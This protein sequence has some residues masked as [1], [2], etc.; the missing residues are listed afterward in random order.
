MLLES[1]CLLVSCVS[2]GILLLKQEDAAQK[3]IMVDACAGAVSQAEEDADCWMPQAPQLGITG[4]SGR[5]G[6]HLDM[7]SCQQEASMNMFGGVSALSIGLL[8]PDA[9]SRICD[10]G[11]ALRW[12]YIDMCYEV[13]FI[14]P[15]SAPVSHCSFGSKQQVM[16]V[17]CSRLD[18]IVPCTSAQQPH[19]FHATAAP[20]QFLVAPCTEQLRLQSSAEP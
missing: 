3:W 15:H 6:M 12:D 4:L 7:H 18:D 1:C 19:S 8:L 10:E 16:F 2:F 20:I 5:G 14:S 11:L 13:L 17:L 9:V